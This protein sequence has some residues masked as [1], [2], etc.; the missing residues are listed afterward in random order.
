MFRW[1]CLTLAL[2]WASAAE[3]DFVQVFDILIASEDGSSP[4]RPE[5]LFLNAS[6]IVLARAGDPVTLYC[7]VLLVGDGPD[8]RYRVRWVTGPLGEVTVAR[9]DQRRARGPWVH[10]R[11]RDRVS[12]LSQ[13]PEN[14]L[15]F[16][17]VDPGDFGEYTCR[18][19]IAGHGGQLFSSIS[20]LAEDVSPAVPVS[21]PRSAPQLPPGSAPSLPPGSAP[22]LP[23]GSAS[24]LPLG[25]A[26]Q[27]P[28]VSEPQLPPGSA[29]SSLQDSAPQLSPGSTPSLPG[30]AP[31]PP[32]GSSPS[33]P[34]SAPQYPGPAHQPHIVALD[35]SAVVRA[36]LGSAVSLH[37]RVRALH[38]GPGTRYRLR[39]E[40]LGPGGVL[41]LAQQD[42][43]SP[44]PPRL[45]PSY[46]ERLAVSSRGPNT[47]LRLRALH[48]DDPGEYR[49]TAG[50]SGQDEEVSSGPIHL[51]K[52]RQKMMPVSSKTA[53]LWLI[54]HFLVVIF[55]M[56]IGVGSC[57]LTGRKNR[58]QAEN[59]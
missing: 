55:A 53:I 26:P 22:Q 46:S 44:E 2:L 14:H 3:L 34:G 40:A 11:Y 6:G 41:T 56:A 43:A 35:T 37:C 47:Q 51:V 48:P 18:G 39:W 17:R 23:L 19:E 32:P 45:H 29:P 21:P 58:I 8:P 13:G 54:L 7:R 1:I 20:L 59:V 24:P 52:E 42:Q 31:S 30:S 4:P 16:S 5:I 27:L 28:L 50:V 38:A 12:L 25:S 57:F 10:P 9:V 49:C 15:H 33:L 36:P